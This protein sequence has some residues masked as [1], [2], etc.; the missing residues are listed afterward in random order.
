[1]K[2]KTLFFALAMASTMAMASP[3]LAQQCGTVKF[4]NEAKGFGFIKPDHGS[5]IFVHASGLL[6]D[7]HENQRVCYDVQNGKKVCKR[8]MLESWTKRNLSG[9]W[10]S[11]TTTGTITPN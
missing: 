4:F 11:T 10:Y 6:D 5:E 1:M 8:L 9:N 3:A 7:I 2:K